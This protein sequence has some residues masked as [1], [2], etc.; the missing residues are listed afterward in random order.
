MKAFLAG[1]ALTATACASLYTPPPTWD[2]EPEATRI[3]ANWLEQSQGFDALQAWE[4]RSLRVSIQFAFARKWQGPRVKF[5][6][7]ALAPET[8][9]NAAYVAHLQPGKLAE[10]WFRGPAS[11]VQKNQP[12][13]VHSRGIATASGMVAAAAEA[14]LPTLLADYAYR[15]APDEVIGDEP[16]SVVESRRLGEARSGSHD[17]IVYWISKRSGA[18]LR[19]A[20][21]RR[22]GELRRVE[23]RPSDVHE[24]DG[25]LIVSRMLVSDDEGDLFE[26]ML[27]NSV[28]DVELADRLFTERNLKVPRFPS[29]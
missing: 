14:V 13:I 6:A 18:A 7:Y 16:C 17:R 19:K 27:R 26:L 23:I 1:A 5:L 3:A 12:R 15:G 25:K 24:T 22:S 21:Y 11:M 2:T 28:S 10:V 4:V 8:M 20:Y 29:F 9:K